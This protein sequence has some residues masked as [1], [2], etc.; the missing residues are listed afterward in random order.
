M[1]TA[2]DVLALPALIRIA[3]IIDWSTLLRCADITQLDRIQTKFM[4]IGYVKRPAGSGPNFNALDGLVQPHN[5]SRILSLHQCAHHE[6][7]VHQTG[8]PNFQLANK[9]TFNSRLKTSECA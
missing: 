7:R 6:S 4:L 2:A 1:R 5:I 3:A 8:T 9:Y